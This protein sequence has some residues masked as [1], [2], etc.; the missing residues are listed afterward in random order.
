MQEYLSATMFIKKKEKPMMIDCVFTQF[1]INE[2][3]NNILS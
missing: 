2:Y 1:Y 3:D